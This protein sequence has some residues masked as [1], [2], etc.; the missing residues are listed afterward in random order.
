MPGL[1]MSELSEE[2]VHQILREL[3]PRG[4]NNPALCCRGWRTQARRIPRQL[5]M[6]GAE[7]LKR[8]EATVVR[9][10]AWLFRAQP[11]QAFGQAMTKQLARMLAGSRIVKLELVA[12][13][14]GDQGAASLA[15]HLP[16]GL[17]YLNLDDNLI[18]EEGKRAV[19]GACEA[20]GIK[21]RI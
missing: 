17:T 13:G 4:L 5:K 2:T 16:P 10:G 11:Y 3:G 19:R 6:M 21:L 20:A 1:M 12:S 15:G 7:E 9:G 14:I 8:A 18:S